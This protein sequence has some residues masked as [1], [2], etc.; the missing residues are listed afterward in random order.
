MGAVRQ[1]LGTAIERAR[2]LSPAP[3]NVL[4]LA[5]FAWRAA[6]VRQDVELMA[7]SDILIER[8][9][10]GWASYVVAARIARSRSDTVKEAEAV[11]RFLAVAPRG[12]ET[13]PALRAAADLME[14]ATLRGLDTA[15]LARWAVRQL[16]ALWGRTDDSPSPLAA[17]AAYAALALAQTGLFTPPVGLASRLEALLAKG[18]VGVWLGALAHDVLADTRFAA[19]ARA[20]PRPADPI[21]CGF[22][23]LRLY[24]LTGDPQLVIEARKLAV[25]VASGPSPGLTTALLLIELESPEQ[26]A[27][28]YFHLPRCAR[29]ATF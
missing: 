23:L 9:G 21:E 16:K 25:S 15:A 5:W 4:H 18:E 20:A 17:S 10:Q 29:C 3:D 7:A 14:G 28:P 8:A 24:R 2:A 6:I 22:A 26:A 1:S 19:A 27:L 13:A 12:R 11:Q